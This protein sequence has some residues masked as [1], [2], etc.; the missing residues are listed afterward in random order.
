MKLFSSII[1]A[2]FLILPFSGSSQQSYDKNLDEK[3]DSLL[4]SMTLREKIGQL[5]MIEVYS[6]RD[7]EYNRAMLDTIS[8]YKPGSIVFFKGSPFAESKLLNSLQEVSDIPMLVA[9]D[10]EWGVA[11]RL[12]SVVSMPR[13]MALAATRDSAMIYNYG[14][15]LGQQCRRL[16][17]HINFAPVVD[18]NS[19]PLNPVINYRSLGENQ[20][21]VAKFSSWFCAGMMSEGVMPVAKHFPG[22]GNTSQ[23]SHKTLPNINE[24]LALID[25]VHLL[26]FREMVSENVWGIM[27]AHVYA[28]ALD[29]TY[30]LPSSLSHKI[31][32]DLL[33]VKMQ[34]KGLIIT[35]ALMMKGVTRGNKSGSIE[36]QALQAGNDLLLMPQ[37]IILTLDS[38]EKAVLDGRISLEQIDES[39]RKVL[40]TK[41]ELN[42]F[43]KKAVDLNN[44]YEDLNKPCYFSSS[45]KIFDEAV[46]LIYDHESL[47]PYSANRE[48]VGVVSFYIEKESSFHKEASK[49]A[50]IKTFFIPDPKK[51]NVVNSVMQNVSD[52]DTLIL[53][54]HQMNYWIRDN[55]RFTSTLRSVINRFAKKHK[56]I[57]CLMGNPYAFRSYTFTDAPR[58]LIVAYER[59][60]MAEISVAKAIFGSIP[61]Q[62]RLP[63]TISK[64]F[65]AGTGLQ[66]QNGVL[67]ESDPVELGFDLKA[68]LEID[69]IVEQAIRDTVMPGCQIMAIKDGIIFYNKSFGYHTY[70]SIIRVENSHLYDLASLTKMLATTLAV[71]KL[72]ENGIIDLQAPLENYLSVSKGTPVGKLHLDRILTHSSGLAPWK[73]FYLHVMNKPD[74][75]PYWVSSEKSATYPV[76]ICNGIYIR[77]EF[78]DTIVQRILRSKLK[79]DQGYKYS[80][81]GFI[82]L[83]FMVEDVSKQDF[84]TYMNETFYYPL[85]LNTLMYNPLSKF[86]LSVIPPTEQDTLF[87]DILV[88]GYVHDQNAALFGG[89]AGQAGLFSNTYDIAVIMQMLMQGGKYEGKQYLKTSSILKFTSTYFDKNRRGLGFD[90]SVMRKYGNACIEASPR[91]YGHSGFTGTYVWSDPDNGLI[92]VFL[93]NRVYPNAENKKIVKQNIRTRIHSLFYKAV[94]KN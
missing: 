32:Y 78:S 4:N 13:F 53:C 83:K 33:R 12:D 94:S 48:N 79:A 22:H 59:N 10:A 19:N 71:M 56:V 34:Y 65:P 8:W 74:L 82:L 28:P 81:L 27:V 54:V 47:L 57:L 38:V 2:L 93:S 88:H 84:Q 86:D 6:D 63:V 20:H 61:F 50:K 64:Y 14:K 49:Y 40:K 9:M 69:E 60:Q 11:M 23:D 39:V 24:N 45:Q 26:P 75:N 66:I 87:R 37:D 30:L 73:P 44:L 89:V 72:Y 3:V 35:D 42:L 31:I 92:Y 76:E 5:L 46:T 36:V 58:A 18:V 52:Y 21:L 70:D 25:S 85:G 80:D 51:T 77:S 16:G 90:K 15:I 7:E 29:N 43:E 67:H 62:G 17:I 55:Y 41:F 91:S 68:L 1:L